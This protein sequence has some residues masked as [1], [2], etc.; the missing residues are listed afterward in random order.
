MRNRSVS[1]PKLIQRFLS[2]RIIIMGKHN[3]LWHACCSTGINKSTA[4]S[5]LYFL[6]PMLNKLRVNS[7][8]FRNKL[9]IRN[10]FSFIFLRF[11]VIVPVNNNQFDYT[12]VQKIEIFSCIVAVLGQHDFS[13]AVVYNEFAS[14]T[15]VCCVDTHWN[16]SSHQRTIKCERPFRSIESDNVYD[17]ML[18]HLVCEKR[19]GKF[20]ALIMILF[21]VI[22]DLDREMGTQIPLSLTE[23]GD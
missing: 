4:M 8:T 17:G 12:L 7:I 20:D 23:R 21:V 18:G 2:P 3:P 5:W 22:G 11:V 19:F 13:L 9:F 10:N 16:A 1:F 6:N 15:V 14:L